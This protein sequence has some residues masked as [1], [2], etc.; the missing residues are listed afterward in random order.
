MLNPLTALLEGHARLKAL[1]TAWACY[2]DSGLRF[3]DLGALHRQQASRDRRES[4]ETGQS[5]PVNRYAEFA[6]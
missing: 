1:S 3:F 6:L 4:R 5:D 2:A